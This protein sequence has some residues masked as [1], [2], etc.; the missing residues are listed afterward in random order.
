MRDLCIYEIVCVQPLNSKYVWKLGKVL[1]Q[2]TPCSYVVEVDGKLIT[3]NRK[4]LRTTSE[5]HIVL[6]ALDNFNFDDSSNCQVVNVSNPPTRKQSNE[7]T[8]VI[9]TRTRVITY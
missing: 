3:R 8:N 9:G 2:Y 1:L 4:F 5:S 6:P 7:F